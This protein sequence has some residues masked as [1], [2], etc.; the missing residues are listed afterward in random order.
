M[1]RPQVA[2]PGIAPASSP[3]APR[4]PPAPTESSRPARGRGYF[5]E[6]EAAFLDAARGAGGS[7]VRD[8]SIGPCRVRLH[9]AGPA[10]VDPLFRAV[11]HLGAAG[12]GLPSVSV[13]IW[14]S[15]STGVRVPPFPW[16]GEDIVAR[17]EVRGYGDDVRVVY[18]PG[19]GGVTM[20]DPVSRRGVFWVPGPERVP[21]YERAAPLRPL[22]N[23]ALA[24]PGRHLVHAG[25]VARNG[26]GVLLA[27]KGGSGKSTVALLCAGAGLDYLGDDYVLLSTEQTPTA[28][29]LYGTAKLAPEGLTRVPFVGRGA[30]EE[31][32][33]EE[34]KLVLDVGRRFPDRLKGAAAVKAVV[35]PRVATEGRTRAS[36]VSAAEALRTLA[37][38]SMLQLPYAQGDSLASMAALV[39]G[40]PAYALELGPDVSNVPGL[41][42]ELIE[43]GVRA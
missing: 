10:L 1:A 12:D 43:A 6:L 11:S 17:G 40:R 31:R 33:P 41:I 13:C 26:A 21:W 36:R 20:F 25:A 3:A 34:E 22:L 14:D 7:F 9:F 4:P 38:S 16:A 23:W 30:G 5:A 37:P 42:T 2:E 27:G 28:F 29:S 35:L 8:L 15:A 24:A 39:A 19:F 18:E 32:G